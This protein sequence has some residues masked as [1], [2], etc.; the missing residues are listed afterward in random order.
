M[1]AEQPRCI[2]LAWVL[3]TLFNART[4][5]AFPSNGWLA[6]NTLI[7]ENKVQAT[8]LL[9]EEAGAIVRGHNGQGQRV[10]YPGATL[11]PGLWGPP[12]VGV[13]GDPQQ[14]GGP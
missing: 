2:K 5:Y 4:G 3:A 9:L 7:H 6:E 13:G 11:I 10:I 8:L 14:V 12:T 1:F